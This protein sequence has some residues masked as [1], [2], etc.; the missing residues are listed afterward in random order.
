M[1]SLCHAPP[2]RPW[3]SPVALPRRLRADG[4]M[5]E[6]H[7]TKSL[8]ISMQ[9]RRSWVFP[10]PPAITPSLELPGAVKRPE[11]RGMDLTSKSSS[12]S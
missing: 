4:Q 3:A 1:P 6:P 10:P 9:T 11:S 12:V 2:G 7:D 5:E 8:P